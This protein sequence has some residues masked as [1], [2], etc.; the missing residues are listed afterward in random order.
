MVFMKNAHVMHLMVH[1][2]KGSHF[3]AL[4]R[5][6]IGVATIDLLDLFPD[7]EST[8]S[9]S[10]RRVTVDLRKPTASQVK[11]DMEKALRASSNAEAPYI[12][13]DPDPVIGTITVLVERTWIEQLEQAFW[14]GLIQI[15]DWDDSGTLDRQVWC[16]NS[17]MLPVGP[18]ITLTPSPLTCSHLRY[19]FV[20][21]I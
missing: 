12:V 7:F 20:S 5:S 2:L 1:G 13:D 9:Q 15:V 4:R 14:T 16:L 17:N 8:D 11:E 3:L 6:P 19:K 10:S 21:V 18:E